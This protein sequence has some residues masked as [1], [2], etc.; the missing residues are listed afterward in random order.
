MICNQCGAENQE[1]TLFCESCGAQM[2]ETAEAAPVAAPVTPKADAMSL[3]K[4]NKWI[5]IAVAAVLLVAV[6]LVCIF[7]FRKKDVLLTDFLNLETTGYNTV[8]SAE[9]EFDHVSLAM[10]LLGEKDI[11]KYGDYD[12]DLSDED[13]LEDWED[14]IK[15]EYGKDKVKKILKFCESIEISADYSDGALSDGDEITVELE[16]DE[17][18]AEELRLNVTGEEKE[19][20]VEGLKP[21]ETI[22]IFDYITLAPSGYDTLGSVSLCSQQ[23]TEVQ[24]GDVT[25][26]FFEGSSGFKISFEDEYGDVQE[27]G[28]SASL[29]TNMSN[30]SNGD[31]LTATVDLRLDEEDLLRHGAAVE[32]TT[33][34]LVV[35]GLPPLTE[36]D[37]LEN[38]VVIFEGVEGDGEATVTYAE[39]TIQIGD[40]SFDFESGDIYMNGANIGDFWYY[41]DY[42]YYLEPGE[43]VTVYMDM[44]YGMDYD[45]GLVL[46]A[47][48]REY[49]VE[50]LATYVT[51]LESMGDYTALA[52][53][54]LTKL[55]EELEDDWVYMVHSSYWGSTSDHE[56]V[57]GPTL[58]K[59]LLS[60]PTVDS[61]YY[62]EN[63]LCFIYQ[64]TVDDSELEAP[65]QLYFVVERYDV[66]RYPDGTLISDDS[67]IYAPSGQET[68]EE[69]FT[70]FIEDSNCAVHEVV[71]P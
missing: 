27:Y 3:L 31:I 30:A 9:V 7:A 64:V 69:L 63:T 58:Y 6:V 4:K 61:Y 44:D 59:V 70:I 14:D 71:L 60:V 53:S 35:E 37:L 2:P 42:T 39:Q 40:Y 12:I 28:F 8:G 43:I 66:A 11:V 38:I 22:N 67:Y 55:N 47:G 25:F 57:E 50:G 23:E 5:L 62:T 26:S 15:D 24:V 34:E 49:T 20:I 16:W 65:V 45:Y 13:E 17:D 18:R 48:S 51:D 52:E 46:A 41:A 36:V 10:Y 19:F 56:I 29:D 21:V 68:Y 33:A 1:G 32:C 54:A